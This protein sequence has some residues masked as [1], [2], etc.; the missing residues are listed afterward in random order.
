MLLRHSFPYPLQ[1]P[2]IHTHIHS[3]LF[4]TGIPT[5]SR[6]FTQARLVTP[7]PEVSQTLERAPST[8]LVHPFFPLFFLSQDK[9]CCGVC[10]AASEL[11][12]RRFN[13]LCGCRATAVTAVYVGNRT[14]IQILAVQSKFSS[15]WFCRFFF[16][17]GSVDRGARVK[18]FPRGCT[19]EL[20]QA[21]TYR[22]CIP[23]AALIWWW[24]LFL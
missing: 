12:R 9:P 11:G 14:R 1:L 24:D 21:Q 17:V 7:K 22:A 15:M 13:L 18:K 4:T 20:G 10:R 3:S 5:E 6:P 8:S 16:W 2:Y 23:T 19:R